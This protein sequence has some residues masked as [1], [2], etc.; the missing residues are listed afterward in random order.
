MFKT[1]E[2]IT[3]YVAELMRLCLAYEV[4]KL[5]AQV[6]P[7]IQQYLTLD[8]CVEIYHLAAAQDFEEARVA[9]YN[10]F[11]RLNTYYYIDTPVK[12]GVIFKK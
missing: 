2:K 8:N 3:D 4:P 5:L 12:Y 7:Q 10:Y 6:T 1:T 11:L 9:A